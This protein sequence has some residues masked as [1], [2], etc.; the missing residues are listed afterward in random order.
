MPNRI[1]REGILT[2]EGVNALGWPEEVFYRRLM[3]VV[4]DF[5]RFYATPKIIRAACYPLHIDKVSDSDIGKWLTACVTAALVRVYPAEDG[6]RY[7][8]LLNFRQQVRAKDSK[9]PAFDAQ[10][11]D[12]CAADATQ[13]SS[14]RAASAPVFV[15]GDEGE[16]EISAPGGA[17]LFDEFWS[18]YPKKKAKDD[19]RKAFD[20]RKPTRALVAVMV[21]AVKRHMASEDWQKDGGKFIPYPATWLNDGRWQDEEVAADSLKPWHETRSGVEAKGESLGLGRWDERAFSVGEGEP[22][23]AYESR[24][25][26]A[27]M[28]AA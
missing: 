28:E 18:A 16:C 25:R 6:K 23:S 13:A 12:T 27:A 7:L 24:V 9:F 22:F 5:G 14:K 20:K 1:L 19:A 15:F 17:G 26:R 8:E 3:S 21:A 4:D 2:S 10:L 11:V